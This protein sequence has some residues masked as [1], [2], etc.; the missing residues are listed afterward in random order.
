MV[1]DERMGLRDIAAFCEQLSPDDPDHRPSTICC[2]NGN[3]K[4]A[5][6]EVELAASMT[7][8]TVRLRLS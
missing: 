3:A 6:N 1:T 5:Q 7:R 8:E 2:A 4:V